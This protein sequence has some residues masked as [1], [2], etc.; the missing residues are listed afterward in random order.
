MCV[1]CI[2]FELAEKRL[3]ADIT[4][5]SASSSSVNKGEGLK[6][7]IQNIHAMKMDCV[8]MRHPVPGS[9]YHVSQF[10]DAVVVNAGD[11]THEHPTQALLDMMS[12]QEKFGKLKSL[13]IAI[14]GDISHSRVALSNIIGLKK[15]GAEV[16][17]R[18]GYIVTKGDIKGATVK[19]PKSTALDDIAI[20]T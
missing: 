11:G 14:V 12:L 3:S 16:K 8:V 2:S 4:N 18:S 5:F 1:L 19:F 15:M 9:C 10:V 6:D 7:T 20:V 13:K 17:L